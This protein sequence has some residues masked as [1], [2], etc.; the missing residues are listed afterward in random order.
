MTMTM[1]ETRF[2]LTGR[3]AASMHHDDYRNPTPEAPDR[4][5]RIFLILLPPPAPLW[6]NWSQRLNLI[7]APK[8][9]GSISTLLRRLGCWLLLPLLPLLSLAP[10]LLD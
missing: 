9:R 5:T 3:V 4:I 1:E 10:P 2:T 7:L 8:K 6:F